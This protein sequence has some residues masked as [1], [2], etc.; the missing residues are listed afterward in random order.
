MLFLEDHAPSHILS[1]KKFNLKC[2]KSQEGENKG[3]A[4]KGTS[5]NGESKPTSYS[6]TGVAGVAPFLIQEMSV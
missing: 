5:K 2:D 4:K 3:A 6:V 1:G